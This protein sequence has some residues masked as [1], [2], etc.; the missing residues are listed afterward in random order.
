M[1]KD[2]KN[3]ELGQGLS[4]RKDGRYSARFVSLNG[5]RI[6]K[7][8]KTLKEAKLWLEDMRYEQR[9]DVVQ[10]VPISHRSM[11]VDMWFT[12]W[13]ENIIFDLSP[14]TRR[15]YKERYDYNI[16]PIIGN[17]KIDDVKPIHCKQVLKEM[18][19]RYAGSTIRQ[20]YITMGTLFKSALMNDIISKHP[21]D[22]VKYS[23]P[24]R[25]VNDIH[26]LTV[27]RLLSIYRKNI[28]N[29]CSR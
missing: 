18:D 21:M 15:N 26:F 13:Y 4:Q 9:H 5:K 12:Q 28:N 29:Q 27:P 2:L 10:I 14:N 17:M 7:Y 24:V 25:A 22:G 19:T 11:T 3:R 20:T 1:G 16:K 8:F 6:E 23:K